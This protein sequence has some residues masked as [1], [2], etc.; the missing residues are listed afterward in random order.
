MSA[1]KFVIANRSAFEIFFPDTGKWI[2]IWPDGKVEGIT[3]PHVVINQIPLHMLHHERLKE[4]VE[5]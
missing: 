4:P 3:E 1:V 2:T 5:N